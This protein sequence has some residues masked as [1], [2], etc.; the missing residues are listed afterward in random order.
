MRRVLIVDD[1]ATM[2]ALYKQT[3]SRLRDASLAFAGDGQEALE[4]IPTIQPHLMFLD[5]NM[6]RMNGLETLGEMRKR[7]FLE[8]TRVVLVST[9][10]TDADIDRGMAA[11]ASA[12]VRKPFKM[13][14]LGELVD[15]FAPVNESVTVRVGEGPQ[16]QEDEERHG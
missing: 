15:R 1:S 13:S 11:G 5:V 14:A 3:L 2:R 4:R 10:G 8:G 6:P 16:G 7:G 9:E 12:Y